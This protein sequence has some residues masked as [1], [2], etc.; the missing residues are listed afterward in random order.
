[1]NKGNY[2]EF[3]LKMSK[4]LERSLFSDFIHHWL[5]KPKRT[6]GEEGPFTLWEETVDSNTEARVQQLAL[7]VSNNKQIRGRFQW[8]QEKNIFTFILGGSFLIEWNE[9]F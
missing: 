2:D 9:F 8:K 4:G 1:M 5:T 6:R 3:I 7:T